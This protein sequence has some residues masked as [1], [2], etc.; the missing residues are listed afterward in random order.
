MLNKAEK[1]EPRTAKWVLEVVHIVNGRGLF[2]DNSCQDFEMIGIRR[3]LVGKVT[4]IT[5]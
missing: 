2:K 3:C 1:S 5:R 4:G